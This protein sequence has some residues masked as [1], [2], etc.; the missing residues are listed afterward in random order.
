MMGCTGHPCDIHPFP[1]K[2]ALLLNKG[3][4]LDILT[5]GWEDWG[6]EFKPEIL[7]RP[8]FPTLLYSHPSDPSRKPQRPSF[9]SRCVSSGTVSPCL[10]LEKMGHNLN[11]A[12]LKLTIH[13][14]RSISKYLVLE[15]DVWVQI[16]ARLLN[17]CVT[18][19]RLLTLCALVSFCIKGK[20]Y[21]YSSELLW[22]WLW[23]E[24]DPKN[25]PWHLISAQQSWLLLLPLPL[26][27][28]CELVSCC[29]TLSTTCQS[30]PFSEELWG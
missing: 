5:R 4:S 28:F 27:F 6:S 14:A 13:K 11:P 17:S 18:L 8:T 25:G 12:E 16:L 20:Y 19:A 1:L 9:L 7:I 24:W 15:T 10:C 21:Y 29:K 2:T 30:P 23:Y 26:F 3:M 22:K